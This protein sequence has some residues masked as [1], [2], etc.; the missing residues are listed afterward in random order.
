ME[1]RSG[2]MQKGVL[3]IDSACNRVCTWVWGMTKE[4]EESE[5]WTVD[6]ASVS[7]RTPNKGILYSDLFQRCK[8]IA[9]RGQA[10]HLKNKKVGVD[11]SK[12]S[13]PGRQLFFSSKRDVFGLVYMQLFGTF[14]DRYVWIKSPPYANLK[15]FWLV[16]W[17]SKLPQLQ[18]LSQLSLCNESTK[19]SFMDQAH[20]QSKKSHMCGAIHWSVQKKSSRRSFCGTLYNK[21]TYG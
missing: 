13:A 17:L 10:R 15:V 4:M 5:G 8:N 19:C 14:N 20:T 11:W 6:I 9:S 21:L 12:R 7:I 2:S 1:E 3:N 16:V 18:G